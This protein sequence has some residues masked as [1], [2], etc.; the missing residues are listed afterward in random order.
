MSQSI[1][2]RQPR[3][4]Q[5]LVNHRQLN[6][7]TTIHEEKLLLFIIWQGRVNIPNMLL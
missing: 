2:L 1:Y 6:T 3:I 4:K 7:I 5:I